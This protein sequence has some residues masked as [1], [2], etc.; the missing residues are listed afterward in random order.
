MKGWCVDDEKD[1]RQGVV[2]LLGE[3][4]YVVRGCEAVHDSGV[5]TRP[6]A[7]SFRGGK[8]AR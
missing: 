1:P 6:S 2:E 7:S 5:P 8:S 3:W 4:V